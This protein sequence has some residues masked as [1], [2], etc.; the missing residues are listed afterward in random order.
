MNKRSQVVSAIAALMLLVASVVHAQTTGRIQ[1]QIVD[2]QGAV[3]PGATVTVASPSLQGALTQ[4]SDAEGRFRFPSVP[5]G[6]YAVK[7]E[8]SNFKTVEQKDVEVGLDRTANV[9][10]TMQLASVTETVTV[11]GTS[12]TIDQTS[13]VTGINANAEMFNRLP[14]RR[15]FYG[16][17]RLAA[18]VTEDNVGPIVYGSSS[19]ENQYIIDGLNT[20]G[21]E[22]GDKGKM[23]NSDFVQEV[24]VMTGGLPAE[25][26]RMT[27]GVVNVLTKSG[28]NQFHGSAFAFGEGGFLQSDNNTASKRPA[29][30]T[31]V[32]D[33]A[34]QA[35]GGVELGGF[36]VKDRLWYFGAYNRVNQ[37]DETTVIRTLTSPGSPAVGAVVPATIN[38]DLYAVKLTAKAGAGHTVN[39]NVNGDPYKREGNVFAVSGPP[40]TFSGEEKKGG[41]DLVGRYNGVFGS[42]LLVSGTVARHKETDKFGGAGRD[43]AQIINQTVTPTALSGGFGFFQDQEFTRDVY[44]ADVS[45][46]LAG[47]DLKG[48]VDYEHISAINNNFNGGAGQRIYQLSTLPNGQGIR[49]IRHRFYVNDRAAGFVRADPTTWKIAVPLTSEPDSRNTSF[50][51]QDSWKIASGFTINGGIRWERQDVRNRDKETAFDLKD[52]WAPR[53]GFVWDVARNNKSKLYAN[54]GRFFENIPMDI[55]IRAFGGEL[56]CFC[57]N[58]DI[59]AGNTIPDPTAPAR[60]SLLGNSVEPVDENLKGQY[61]DEW[62]AGYEYELKQ[63]IVVGAKYTHRNLG[64]VIEDFLIPA[65]GEYF[66]ANPGKGIGTEMGFYDFEHTAPAPKPKRVENAFEV[67]AQKRFSR[68]WQLIANLVF[69]KLEGNYDGT[70]QASTGQL[71][72]N[73]N[74]AFDYADFLVNADGRLSNDRNVQFKLFGT[75]VVPSGKVSGLE[76]GLGTHWYSG[77]PLNA[78][79]Y[80]TAYQNWEYYLAPRGSVGRGPADWE[81]DL[82]VAYP[83]RFGGNMRLN[84]IADTF[85]LFDRQSITQLDQR[86]NITADGRCGGI[87]A[88]L[89]NGDGGLVTTGNNL[90]PAGT[91]NPRATAS[92]PDYLQKGIGFTGQRSIRLGVRFTF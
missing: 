49:Y 72:P 5:P 82:H 26:G 33:I 65:D 28:S 69:S 77:T 40:S 14:V 84:L 30:T 90:T 6:R 58:F 71:D 9:P 92:N 45:Y 16:L 18:G 66:I 42:R 38:R 27:G 24:Q 88:A 47:N 25:Y 75:Y 17:T 80:S 2:A 10:L 22:L 78:Y 91:L 4:V 43:T 35:D 32:A 7:A 74:S 36:V 29:T 31:T 56:Q 63:N 46:Y 53:I 57:Y 12:P 11:T 52:N 23:L 48:G 79:G 89:C 59:S 83:L 51:V 13:T 37:R 81:T 87:P 20:T 34:H 85:N 41:V 39:F 68:G 62:I 64:R 86:Y 54:W 70:F 67:S 8:L 44:K 3:V 61:L 76:I 73:I 1:G 60:S 50:Y 15:D 19:A 55:N 21:V